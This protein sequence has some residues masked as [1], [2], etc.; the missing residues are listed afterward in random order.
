[1]DNIGRQNIVDFSTG[2]TI[3][4]TE[5]VLVKVDGHYFLRAS[6]DDA[7]YTAS[8][9]VLR[10][11]ARGSQDVGAEIDVTLR[12]P[13]NPHLLSVIGY[14]HFFPGDFIEDTGASQEIDWG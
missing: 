12:Y 10:A 9:A 7:V 8:G 3:N 6:P 1:M 14:S 2:F 11:D 5:K 4:M 13:I